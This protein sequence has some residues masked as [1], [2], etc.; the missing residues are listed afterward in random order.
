MLVQVTTDILECG[1]INSFP[2]MH[3][4]AL[5]SHTLYKIHQAQ[6]RCQ[7]EKNELKHTRFIALA[8]V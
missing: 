4:I 3:M 2:Q 5:K 7:H 1:Y 8:N 6:R